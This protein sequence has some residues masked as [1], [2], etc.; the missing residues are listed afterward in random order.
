MTDQWSLSDTRMVTLTVKQWM[1]LAAAC[2]LVASTHAQS[3]K[4]WM[5]QQEITQQVSLADN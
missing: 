5:L 3:E 1:D 2:A 4:Y